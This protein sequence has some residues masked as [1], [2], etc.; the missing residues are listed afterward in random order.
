MAQSINPRLPALLLYAASPDGAAREEEELVFGAVQ[1][2]LVAH[3]PG[4]LQRLELRCVADGRVLLHAAVTVTFWCQ[5]QTDVRV[6]MVTPDGT[7]W[8]L[9]FSS[10]ADSS[11]FL[12]AIGFARALATSLSAHLASAAAQTYPP[13]TYV[14]VPPTLQDV[15]LSTGGH[16]SQAEGGDT[17]QV[18]VTA[19]LADPFTSPHLPPLKPFL[20]TQ[21]KGVKLLLGSHKALEALEQ[22]IVGMRKGGR[23]FLSVSTTAAGRGDFPSLPPNLPLNTLLFLD[24]TLHRMRKPNAS[25]S[26]AAASPAGATAQGQSGGAASS[27]RRKSSTHSLPHSST[28]SEADVDPNLD[29]N[30]DPDM[31]SDMSDA[32]SVAS[33]ADS[34]SSS[35]SSRSTP[36]SPSKLFRNAWPGGLSSASGLHGSASSLASASAKTPPGT[37]PLAGAAAASGVPL[38]RTSMGRAASERGGQEAEGVE[39]VKGADGVRRVD[40]VRRLDGPATKEVGGVT[41][42][43]A[44][45]RAEQQAVCKDN[46]AVKGAVVALHGNSIAAGFGGSSGWA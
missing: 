30:L 2:A 12:L 35:F 15:L 42:G 24:I 9:M 41:A 34:I 10:A 23:R 5:P 18:A 4:Q 16:R 13:L 28:P 45:N 8:I 37:P 43:A 33:A 26:L 46:A 21:G 3:G 39:G 44:A 14:P 38:G 19:W 40:A 25:A 20:V 6:H 1:A 36:V 29:P 11:A 22:G 17:V 27:R 31:D 7:R 32:L